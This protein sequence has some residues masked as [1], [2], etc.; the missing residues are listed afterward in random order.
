MDNFFFINSYGY[1]RECPKFAPPCW[2]PLH[3]E[4]NFLK[5]V[6]GAAAVQ[7][8]M[9]S[10][11]LCPPFVINLPRW[12]LMSYSTNKYCYC[13]VN[14]Y[15]LSRLTPFLIAIVYLGVL[16]WWPYCTSFCLLLSRATHLTIYSS[17]DILES[18]R[19]S[20]F[21]NLTNEHI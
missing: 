2:F 15:L 8:N 1:G 7:R 16:S 9:C 18:C 13:K 3:K 21:T 19:S 12:T 6:G 4:M 17:V 20:P 14:M 11:M 10:R 5:A